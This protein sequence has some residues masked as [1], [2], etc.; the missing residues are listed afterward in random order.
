MSKVSRTVKNDMTVMVD[1]DVWAPKDQHAQ[2]LMKQWIGQRVEVEDANY[3]G[4]TKHAARR[5]PS[6]DVMQVA[7]LHSPATGAQP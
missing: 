3:W 5:L 1:G 6:H 2:S 7:R 4:T